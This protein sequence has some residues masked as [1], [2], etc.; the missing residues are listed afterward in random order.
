V[1]IIGRSEEVDFCG[2]RAR[3]ASAEDLLVV[4]GLHIVND[5]WK[6]K[7][8]LASWRDFL[9]I[10]DRIG[11]HGASAAFERASLTW[12]FDL[13]MEEV[14]H[15]LPEAGLTATGSAPALSWITKFRLASSGWAND[16]L[17]TRHKMAWATRLPPSNALAFMAGTTVPSREYVRSHDGSYW[18][19]WRRGIH[20]TASAAKGADMRMAIPDWE[21]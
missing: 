7:L 1:D 2:T 13:M 18:N 10:V 16:S 17:P 5:L 21:A 14:A 12:M 6:G 20:E 8:G 9:V 11:T 4:S 3:F 19:Y 15:A